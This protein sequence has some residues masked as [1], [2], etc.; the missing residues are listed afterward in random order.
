MYGRVK[1]R[2]VKQTE[3]AEPQADTVVREKNVHCFKRVA[4]YIRTTTCGQ[5]GHKACGRVAKRTSA[6]LLF[7]KLSIG[8][9]RDVLTGN[10]A[11]LVLPIEVVVRCFPPQPSRTELDGA[12]AVEQDMAIGQWLLLS[13]KYLCFALIVT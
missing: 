1:D 11:F 10:G 13:E 7:G 9:C 12:R 8:I 5:C 2:V 6:A 3:L 4:I